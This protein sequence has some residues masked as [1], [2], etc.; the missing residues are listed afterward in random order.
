MLQKQVLR[1]YLNTFTAMLLTLTSQRLAA[2]G[3]KEAEA[4]ASF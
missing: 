1:T 4:S 2:R 3:K